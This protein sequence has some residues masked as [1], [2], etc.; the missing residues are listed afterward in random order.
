MK[1]KIRASRITID[2]ARKI[3]VEVGDENSGNDIVV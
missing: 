3:G 2:I 1:S